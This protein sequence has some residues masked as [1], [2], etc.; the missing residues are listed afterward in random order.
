M[1]Q[2]RTL[3]LLGAGASY[4]L[5]PVTQE[6]RRFIKSDYHS[7]G[8]YP[9]TSSPRSQLFERV[10]GEIPFEKQDIEEVLL[11]HMPPAALDL[12]V[13]RGLWRPSHGVVPSQYA[14]F[15]VVGSPSTL[16]NFNLDGLA[17]LYCGHRH[18]IMEMH[19]RIDHVLFERFDYRELLEAAVIYNEGIPHL[20]PK[21]LPQPEPE[22][23]TSH[24][25]YACARNLFP[26]FRS[27]IIL[28][29]SFG[30]RSDG[31]DDKQS[32]DFFVSLMRLHPRPVFVIS[33]TP[34]DLA[35][36]LRDKLSSHLVYDIPLRWELFSGAVLANADPVHG[37]VV[38]R[39]D[40]TLDGVI[41]A[42]ESAFDSI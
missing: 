2:P 15:E 38:D 8:I 17:S 42:Y 24:P 21:L 32:F 33:S 28:G 3:Y 16:C 20:S 5:V 39:H 4:G 7:V 1:S 34:Q 41:R 27:V 11:T 12:L 36:M 18:L 35:E 13:Q 30:Q 19:G 26:R 37:L 14:V 10:I 29:Y 9:V 31:L 40:R 25:N 6:L 23:M 22:H